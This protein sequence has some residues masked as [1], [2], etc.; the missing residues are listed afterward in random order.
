MKLAFF[1]TVKKYDYIEQLGDAAL[2]LLKQ[3]KFDTPFIAFASVVQTI[4]T[5][6]KV[7]YVLVL[8]K[9]NFD[10]ERLLE[11]PSVLHS[12]RREPPV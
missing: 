11:I 7:N 9:H 2:I 6:T 10:P 12:T 4:N 8:T 1:K 5:M 3:Q